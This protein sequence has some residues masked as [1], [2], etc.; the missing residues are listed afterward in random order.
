MK[1]LKKHWS[2]RPLSLMLSL[3]MALP[4]LGLFLLRGPAV[5]A[6]VLSARQPTWAV[7]DFA[8]PSG[9]GSSDV[10]RLASDSF[11]VQLAKLN[12]YQ[13]LPRE[14]LL[15]GIQNESLTP[16]LNLS[17]IERLGQS[18]GVDA[19]V[20][21]EISSISFSRDRRQAKVSL[22][23][24]VIDP[25]SGFLLN[26]ALAEG[27]SNPRPIPV[28]DEEQLVNEAF[29]NAAFNAVKQLSR[30]A[31]PVATVLISGNNTLNGHNV[32][33]TINKGTRDGMYAGLDMLISRGGRYVGTIRI[34]DASDNDSNAEITDLGLG[35]EPGDRATAIYHLPAYTVDK[36]TG[37]YQTATSADLSADAPTTSTHSSPFKGLG[38]ILIALLSAGLLLEAIKAGHSD[39]SLGGANVSG[40]AAISGR[41]TDVGGGSTNL[42][43]GY[44]AAGGFIPVAVRITGN[45]GNINSQ[46]FLEFH[47]YRSDSPSDLSSAQLLVSAGVGVVSSASGSSTST[48]TNTSGTTGTTTGTTGTTTTTGLLG[49]NGYG[50]VPLFAQAS[51]SL[52]VFDDFNLKTT[53]TA[54]KPDPTDSTTLVTLAVSTFGV[55][56]TTTTT[57]INTDF[58]HG[59]PGT[60]LGFGSRVSYAIEGL[61]IQPSTIS[62]GTINPGTGTNG[63]T[64]ST[65]TNTSTSGTSTAGTTTSTTTGTTN[66]SGTS[67]NTNTNTSG[68]TTTG[69][70][71][72]FQLTGLRRTNTITYIEPVAVS[73]AAVTNTGST[74]V[75]VTVPA[76]AGA[77]DYI[78]QISDNPGFNS[79]VKTYAAAAGAYTV[80]SPQ[81]NPNQSGATSTTISVAAGTAV[82]FNN[83]NLNTDF[84]GSTSLFYRVGA[85]DSADNGQSGYTNNYIFSDPLSLGLTGAS[86]RSSIRS[87]NSLPKRGRF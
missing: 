80:L 68:T 23:I 4:V 34:A 46:N 37:S 52:E 30:F 20:A 7:L 31:L 5:Q 71:E 75:N 40:V 36:A 62:T 2:A 58:I 14:Q 83:I 35:I 41:A 38:G 42:P 18:L 43:A 24:R 55:T 16:P 79:N 27:L 26:G 74:N 78:L 50:Q 29:G 73:G 84:P 57:T 8:N 6:Q 59:I 65:S 60:G 21:G 69:H 45:I 48:N 12:R 3:L 66:T 76:T 25:K 56:S 17:S 72:T 49:I 39:N 13:V 15:T 82:V 32:T 61:Y 22:A 87:M 85:R 53:V 33:V 44:P 54:S 28:D 81:T 64:T 63:N 47:V 77:N 10:G 11:V 86:I 1:H 9:Y 19:I 67:T 51:K 70:D